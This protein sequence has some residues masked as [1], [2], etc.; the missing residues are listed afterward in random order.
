M[1]SV[2]GGENSTPVLWKSKHS[3]TA[4]PFLQPLEQLV[5]NNKK[6]GIA[7]FE[8]R[9]KSHASKSCQ[10]LRNTVRT[11]LLGHEQHL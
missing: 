10:G 6:V 11:G 9:N 8:K 4:K 1:S 7:I 3:Q 5:L 2:M